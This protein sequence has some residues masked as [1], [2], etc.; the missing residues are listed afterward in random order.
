MENYILP[1]VETGPLP[2]VGVNLH[3]IGAGPLIFVLIG[4]TAIFPICRI[5]GS[6]LNAEWYAY[7]QQ[8]LLLVM[9]RTG[10]VNMY[11]TTRVGG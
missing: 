4:N 11:C 8:R 3:E 7:Y 1:R 2:S 10:I 6:S 5:E 9:I